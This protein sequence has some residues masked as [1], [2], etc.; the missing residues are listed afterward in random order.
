MAY[1]LR[2]LKNAGLTCEGITTP[3]GF[4]NRVLPELAQATLQACRDV[5]GAEIP[6]YFRHLF[7]DDAERR[8]AGRVRL[9]AS[10]APDPRVRRLDHRLH[11]RLVRRL[12]RPDR[13]ARSTSSSPRTA[14]GGRLPEV[15]ARGEPA[16]MVCHWPGIYFNGEEVGFKIFKEVVAAAARRTTTTRLDEAQRDRALLGG[17]A[18]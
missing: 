17:A 14:S 8:P 9:R 2:I 13:A 6:H 11:G 16:M 15:I 3:G 4:G 1:A 18:S 12:G 7:T 10:T 5:F